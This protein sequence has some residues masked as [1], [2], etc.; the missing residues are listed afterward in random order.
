MVMSRIPRVVVVVLALWTATAAQGA[1]IIAGPMVGAPE[2][3][4]MPLWVQVDGSAEVAFRYWPQ[5]NPAQ[6]RET[7]SARA[8]RN[9]GYAVSSVAGPLEPGTAYQYEVRID[10]ARAAVDADT[11]FTTMPF[12]TDRA[13]PPDFT[14]AL[15][16]GHLVNDASYDP[17]N[18]IPGDGYTVFLAILAK[19]PDFM[20]WAGDSV[21]LREP[22]WG[23]RTGMIARYSKNRATPELQPLL[24]SIPHAA[25][26]SEGELGPDNAGKHFRNLKDAH[27]VFALFWP[28]Q[29]P[30]PSVEGAATTV[31]YGDAEFFLLDDRTH[32][33]LQQ[34]GSRKQILGE[35]QIEWLRRSLQESPATF[36]IVVLGGAALSPSD[37]PRNLKAAD[38]EQQ[39]LLERLSRDRIGGLIFVAGG[40]DFGEL[41]KM[42]RANAP[43]L[44]ELSLGPLTDRPAERTGELNFYRVPNTSTF[45]RQFATMRFHGDEADRKV[46]LTVFDING[47]QLWSQTL[48]EHDM[49]F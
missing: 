27:E 39:E 16:S 8:T 21:H 4:A 40:K 3:R 5:G 46:T 33:D 48:A 31:R 22:D 17:L 28:G 37:S 49:R 12:F 20:I 11:Q 47:S 38:D 44:Y 32:R 19:Q 26:F 35:A 9:N 34:F 25:V 42:V 29:T 14:V 6:A 7:E 43:D 2:M 36:K 41:T 15:G 18:R 10:G 30:A 1:R 23:S 13:P 24:A 45:T